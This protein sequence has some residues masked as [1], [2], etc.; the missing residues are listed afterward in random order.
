VIEAFVAMP[1]GSD[2]ADHLAE[3]VAPLGQV[4]ARRMFGG[5]GLYLD[6]TMFG[7]IADG[8]LY[9]KVDDANRPAFQ[10]AGCMP[11]TYLARGAPRTIGSFWQAPGEMLETR[12]AAL[13]WVRGALD[14]ALRAGAAKR[15]A[16]RKRTPRPVARERS[17]AARPKTPSAKRGSG[18]SRGS[19]PSPR[20]PRARRS[21]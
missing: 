11:F 20:P 19:K 15:A 7:L 21:R 6:G 4:V 16:T 12:D 14:A 9:L 17:A 10:A 18:S 13:V 3:L 2:L 8:S 1:A 5:F